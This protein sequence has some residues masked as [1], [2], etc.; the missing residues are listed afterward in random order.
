MTQ[1]NKK[2]GNNEAVKH[3]IKVYECL[4]NFDY[5]RLFRLLEDSPNLNK[6]LINNFLPKIRRKAL[7][8]ISTAFSPTISPH[9]LFS[10][11][12]F[13]NQD[14]FQQFLH[15]HAVLNDK[16]MIDCKKTSQKLREDD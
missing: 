3:S 12:H 10:T 1:K 13:E 7:L 5:V 9:Y 8:V 6:H 15:K 14:S 4:E 2:K 16:N 11:L